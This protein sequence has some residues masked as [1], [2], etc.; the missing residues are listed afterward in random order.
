[1]AP[2]AQKGKAGQSFDAQ[3][4][5]VKAALGV[6]LVA[7]ICAV[8]Y[9]GL[10]MQLAEDIETAEGR[11]TQLLS[12]KTQAEQRQARFLQLTQDLANREAA[13]RAHKRVLPEKAEIAAFLDDLNR[14]AELNGLRFRMVEPRPEE[15]VEMYVKIPVALQLNGRFHE[16]AKFFYDVS[17][18]ERAINMENVMLTNPTLEGENFVLAISVLATTFRRPSEEEVAAQAGTEPAAGEGGH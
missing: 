2:P 17:R 5:G 15:A 13:D 4:A 3:P 18:L 9:F 10:H 1:M 16:I 6:F 7:I 11:Y 14:L 8:Y 12:E